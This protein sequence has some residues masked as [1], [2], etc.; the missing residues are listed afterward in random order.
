MTISKFRHDR[1]KTHR[2]EPN[3][4]RIEPEFEPKLE[5]VSELKPER[6]RVR[7]EFWFGSGSIDEFLL[8]DILKNLEL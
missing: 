5:F 4:T 7:F 2:I 8:L 3:R 1:T 6:I